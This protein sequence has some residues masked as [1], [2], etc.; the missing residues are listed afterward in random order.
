ME[1]QIRL[2]ILSSFLSDYL[3]RLTKQDASQLLRT[4]PPS[5]SLVIRTATASILWLL[6]WRKGQVSGILLGLV[7]EKEEKELPKDTPM[8][9]IQDLPSLVFGSNSAHSSQPKGNARF[10]SAIHYVFSLMLWEKELVW[11]FG[12]KYIH[13]YPSRGIILSGILC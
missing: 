4:C 7:R 3:N 11:L 1:V 5:A 13:L 12:Q 8:Q 6:W 10:Q 9:E 2:F